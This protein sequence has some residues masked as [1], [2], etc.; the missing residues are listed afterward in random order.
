MAVYKDELHC[1]YRGS[2][3]DAKL[4]HIIYDGTSWRSNTMP[5][6][7]GDSGPAL[8]VYK[9]KLHLVRRGTGNDSNLWHAVYDGNQWSG[10]HPISD[11]YSASGPSMV[12]WVDLLN[13]YYRST[14]SD[15]TLEKNVYNGEK[16]LGAGRM[17]IASAHTPGALMVNGESI[18][19]VTV[20]NG[21]LTDQKLYHTSTK[22]LPMEGKYS[23]AGPGLIHYKDP[24]AKR[25]QILCVHRGH[26]PTAPPPAED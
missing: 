13:V 12:L 16:W 14:A 18:H 8:I 19:F 9:D 6:K 25:D 21:S 4:Y 5:D 7:W 26:G 1:V 20:G 17:D 22:T 24:Y 2:G 10:D 23:S 15:T 11:S 3:G